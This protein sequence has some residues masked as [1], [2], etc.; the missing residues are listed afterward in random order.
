MRARRAPKKR[1]IRL[2]VGDREG[3]FRLGL[4]KLFGLEDDLRVVAQAE[5]ELQALGLAK[6]FRPDVLFV[7]KEILGSDSAGFI[8]RLRHAGTG[9][10]I[11]VMLPMLSGED[12]MGYV[13]AGAAG[14]IIKSDELGSFARSARKVAAGELWLPSGHF[15]LPSPLSEQSQTRR[16][17]PVDTLT[18]REK[19]IISCLL[20][21]WRNR[22]IAGHLQITEQTVKNH[23]RTIFDKVGVSDRLEL[24]L[25]VIHQRLELPPVH[26]LGA[27][28]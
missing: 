21:G 13:K 17:R 18:R 6:K 28:A 22:E 24:A 4:R 14:V 20:Q 19:T 8:A 15:T 2:L 5:N 26:T 12:P 11:I 1:R 3:V 27:E 10:R 9:G 7:S 25:Y 16:Q 23:F